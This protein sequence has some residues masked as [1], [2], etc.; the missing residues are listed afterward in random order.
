MAYLMFLSLAAI[1]ILSLCPDNQWASNHF[2]LWHRAPIVWLRHFRLETVE[3]PLCWMCCC[4]FFFNIKLAFLTGVYFVCLFFC[5]L[6]FSCFK[7]QFSAIFNIN[8]CCFRILWVCVFAFWS[9][10]VVLRLNMVNMVVGVFCGFGEWDCI[11]FYYFQLRLLLRYY[12]KKLKKNTNKC[13][14]RLQI[15]I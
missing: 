4:C 13:F 1:Q 15:S 12:S 7:I 9:I 2:H 8:C 10:D 3:E 11:F 6:F 14:V 5:R